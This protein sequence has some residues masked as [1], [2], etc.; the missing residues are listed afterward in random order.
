MRMGLACVRRAAGSVEPNRLSHEEVEVA[1]ELVY[2]VIGGVVR[3][4]L[5]QRITEYLSH[6]AVQISAYAQV[7]VDQLIA[8]YA[9]VLDD[10]IV[11][12]VVNDVHFRGVS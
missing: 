12:A 4:R 6:L 2:R 8:A 10:V 11:I 1:E 7:L 9:G 5:S 3:N